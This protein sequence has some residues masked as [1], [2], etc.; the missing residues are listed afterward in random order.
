MK[1]KFLLGLCLALLLAG[2]AST[3]TNWD[4]RVGSLTYEQ[5]VAELGEPIGDLKKT[6]GNRDVTWLAERG[7]PQRATYGMGDPA[8]P[9]A[10]APPARSDFP[11][12]AD[13]YLH[14]VFGPDGRLMSWREDRGPLR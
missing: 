9:G 12:Q 10:V 4:Q 7:S 2:C 11:P 13:R 6:D 3:S 5:A 14:F 1:I 8:V